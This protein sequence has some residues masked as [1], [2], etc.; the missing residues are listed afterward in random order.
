MKKKFLL[1][2]LAIL[3]SLSISCSCF[4]NDTGTLMVENRSQRGLTYS[5]VVD[6]INKGPVAPGQRKSFDAPAGDRILVFEVYGTG[7][8]A[9]QPAIVHIPLC[10]TTNVISCDY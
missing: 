4:F 8:I 10:G 1:L 7:A 3:L 9:C 2:I 5:V 6:N